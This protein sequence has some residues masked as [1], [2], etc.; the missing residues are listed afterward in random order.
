MAQDIDAILNQQQ[1]SSDT[2][3]SLPD[4]DDFTNATTR[5]NIYRAPTYSAALTIGT[6]KDVVRAFKLATSHNIP[7]LATGGRHG[8]G[9][10]IS[11]LQDGLALD[12]SQMRTLEVDV[13]AGT[14][15]VG[16]GIR[17]GDVYDPVYNA[18]YQLPTGVCAAVSVIGAT[19]GAG[20]GRLQGAN[21]LMLDALLS[22]RVV[23]ASGEVLET[24]S[25]SNPDLF[26]ALRGAGQ[27]FGIVTSATYKL[28]P[29]TPIYTS[30]DLIFPGTVHA[31]FFHELAKFKLSGDWAIAAYIG[32]DLSAG[33]PVIRASAVYHGPSESAI[34]L[35]SPILDLGP[36]YKDIQELPW[37]K[38]N[39]VAGFSS[40]AMI[41]I[42]GKTVDVYG[43]NLR[44]R[45]AETWIEVFG[46][47]KEF[48]ANTPAARQ[49]VVLFEGW[50]N[51][52]I[53]KVSDDETAYP[54]RDTEVYVMVQ[55]TW[56]VGDTATAEAIKA[57]SLKVR[58]TLAATSGYGGLTVYSNYANGDETLEQIYGERKLPRLAKLKKK[59]DPNNVFRFHHVLPVEYP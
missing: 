44:E 11:Q 41:C 3:L 23:T 19:L 34:P 22:A 51:E 39:H 35:L 5:W 53:L 13:K 8:Y 37:N 29:L 16:P 46:I 55:N 17:I 32:F 28:F 6:T 56:P 48:Y 50:G 54:W 47:M 38:L 31:A 45:N 57:N 43:L 42:P 24:S 14:L 2:V 15:T 18:G 49:C 9:T 26:W 20:V 21:G 36:L 10:T 30:I 40:D 52:A 59:Y 4:T 27:N 1:W 25:T 7:F 12:L 33:E 58:D